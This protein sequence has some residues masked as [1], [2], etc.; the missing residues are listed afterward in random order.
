[1]RYIVSLLVGI[2]VLAIQLSGWAAQTADISVPK[3]GSYYYWFT[4]SD[5][6]NSKVTT[7]PSSFNDKKTTAD[8]PLVKDAVAKNAVLFVLNSKTG[9]E[10]IVSVPEHSTS[11]KFALKDSDFK[12]A[13][14]TKIRVVS[15]SNNSPVAACVV[16]IQ[17]GEKA[18]GSKSGEEQTRTLN[19][20][21]E[22]VAEFE[23]LPIGTT[24][25]TI[26]YGEGKTA[27][28]DIDIP[29]ERSELVPSIEVP[30]VGEVDTVQVAPSA[31]PNKSSKGGESADDRRTEAQ[32]SG[33]NFGSAL[34]GLAL[35]AVILYGLRA[36]LRKNGVGFQQI[37][38]QAGVDL[39]S[40]DA[41][42]GAAPKAAHAAPVDPTVCP[43]C[44]GKKDPSTGA[45]ACSVGGG[46][47]P[48]ASASQGARLVATQGAYMGNIYPLASDSATIG[49]EE[50]N[51]LAFPQD[52][53]ISR[54]HARLTS[55]GGEWTVR[56]EGS[57]NGTFVNG[58]KIT[59][60]TLRPGDEIQ[61]GSTRLRI[62]L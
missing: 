29:S 45:C 36:V 13:C 22:G 30:V 19:P 10:A 35:I 57:S 37:L 20:A 60:Q 15:A 12:Y 25:V 16:K 62:E 40:D 48:A 34:V 50:T 18:K 53:A 4:Y 49:R 17:T 44:G 7:M 21:E 27:S 39:P 56:D 33:I 51:D 26:E 32:G 9:N 24:K 2:G 28:Q 59:E 42:A 23:S 38:K 55:N 41:N 14:R 52:I 11:S 1:L 8:L 46:A 5:I 47:Q 61:V 43:F 6:S 58:I 54:R 3:S 31:A